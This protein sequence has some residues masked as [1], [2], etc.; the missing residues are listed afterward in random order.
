MPFSLFVVVWAS[1]CSRAA[2]DVREWKPADHDRT[3]EEDDTDRVGEA[4]PDGGARVPR[5]GSMR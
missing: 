3:Q 1:G 2:A 5:R 4:A